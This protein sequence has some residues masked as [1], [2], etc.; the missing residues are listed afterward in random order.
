MVINCAAK[1]SKDLDWVM[2]IRVFICGC[3]YLFKIAIALE[4]FILS[5]IAN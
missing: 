2:L 5:R 4:L 1:L 3:D